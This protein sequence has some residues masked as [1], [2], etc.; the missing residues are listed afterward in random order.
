M[1]ESSMAGIFQALHEG[2][3]SLLISGHDHHFEQ[4]GRANAKAKDADKGKS[5]HAKDGVR[6]FVVGTGGTQ[7]HSR[8]LRK[9]GTKEM[10]A[11]RTPVGF[12]GGSLQS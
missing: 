8:P 7:L 12:S 2:G 3:A 5:A 4:L 9:Q 1:P 11:V 6:S 10:P